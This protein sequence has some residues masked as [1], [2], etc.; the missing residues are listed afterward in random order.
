LEFKSCL[1]RYSTWKFHS[2]RDV[3]SQMREISTCT[4]RLER[5]LQITG[6][7]YQGLNS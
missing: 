2:R 7:E 5:F 4:L 1:V 3:R 6:F